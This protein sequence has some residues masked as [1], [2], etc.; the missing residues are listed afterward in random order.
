M[1][2][3]K[4][5]DKPDAISDIFLGMSPNFHARLP[6]SEDW[7]YQRK[8]V[9][10]L[11]APAFL[12]SVAAPQL[13]LSFMDLINMWS[14]KARLAEGRPF[15][16]KQDIYETAL[17]AA[18]AAIFGIEDTATVTRNQTTLLSSKQTIPL[19]TS[20]DEEAQLP[21]AH[22]PPAFHAVLE[23]TEGIENI[24]KSPFPTFSS[25]WQRYS[26]S[27]RSHLAVKKRDLAKEIAKAELRLKKN[28]GKEEKIT[29]A[30]DHFLRKEKAFAEKAGRAP[31]Y[32]TEVMRDEVS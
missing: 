1:R 10:D 20:I 9:Q 24:V 5:F 31:K 14:E 13:H 7:R 17:E 2:R 8:I 22:A 12:N 32:D 6:T 16:I 11:V 26:P 21:R 15:T 29:N 3:T 23:L 30:V 25:L 27:G 28:E 19:P 4:E 18:W